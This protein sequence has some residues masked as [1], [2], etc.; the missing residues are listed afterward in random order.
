[1]FRVLNGNGWQVFLSVENV[2]GEGCMA[3][4]TMEMQ[5]RN[6]E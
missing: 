4:P 6:R 2:H 3:S 5:E 1:M